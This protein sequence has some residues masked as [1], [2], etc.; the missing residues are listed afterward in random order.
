MKVGDTFLHPYQITP[1][2]CHVR[3]SVDGL[4]VCR[5][6][7]RSKQCWEYVVFDPAEVSDQHTLK[8]D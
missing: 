2:K 3:G 8:E 7:R 4:L 1:S 5:W 6:W